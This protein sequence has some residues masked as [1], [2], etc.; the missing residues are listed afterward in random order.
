MPAISDDQSGTGI[1]DS[2]GSKFCCALLFGYRMKRPSVGTSIE[3]QASVRVVKTYLV[4]GTSQGFPN[5]LCSPLAC[6]LYHD[7]VS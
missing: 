5:I 2:L 3:I 1:G 4:S 6:C 7:V